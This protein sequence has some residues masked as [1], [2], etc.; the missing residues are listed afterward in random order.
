LLKTRGQRSSLMK[1]GQIYG[2]MK[3]GF[4]LDNKFQEIA[5][6]IPRLL[7]TPMKNMSTVSKD[8]KRN[9]GFRGVVV[10]V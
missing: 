9:K 6:C 3:I 4:G 2:L 7:P 8:K 5:S 1:M 10:E